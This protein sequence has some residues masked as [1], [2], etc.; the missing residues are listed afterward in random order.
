MSTLF[1]TWIVILVVLLLIRGFTYDTWHH[2]WGSAAM[3][4][5][6]VLLAGGGIKACHDS[7][8]HQAHLAERARIEQAER[9]PHVVREVDGCK[10]YRFRSGDH[11]HFFT[12]C[13]DSV[14]STDTGRT[15]RRGR[16]S[17]TE[18]STIEVRP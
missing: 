5:F 2:E 16:S 15:E 12:R 1:W 13:P 14:T 3:F 6:V 9:Q 8:S 10:V 17:R 7:D 4:V 11:W 18:Y